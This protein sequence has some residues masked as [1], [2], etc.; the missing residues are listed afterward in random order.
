MLF[1]NCLKSPIGRGRRNSE[2]RS[3]ISSRYVNSLG[4]ICATLASL[5]Y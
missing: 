2:N 4:Q 3:K 5:D 1:I